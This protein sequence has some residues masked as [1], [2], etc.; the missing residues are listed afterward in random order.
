M[1]NTKVHMDSLHLDHK[2]W[3]NQLKFFLDE[4]KIFTDWLGQ[5]S[6][7]NT[8]SMLKIKVEQFQNRILI[9][10]T[11]LQKLLKQIQSHEA[12]LADLAKQNTVA[13]DH[14]LF[15]DHTKMRSEIEVSIDIQQSLKTEFNRF[16]ADAF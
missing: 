13:S 3:G 2:I 8:D 7:A 10:E 15:T 5:V 9:Q 4:L 11:N 16:I 6:M 12:H 14:L 1:K